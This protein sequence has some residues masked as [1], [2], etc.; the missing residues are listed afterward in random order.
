MGKFLKNKLLLYLIANRISFLVLLYFLVIN[1]PIQKILPFKNFFDFLMTFGKRWD[2][3]SYAFIAD[4]WYVTAGAE[5]FFIVFP[6][7]YPILIKFLTLFGLG[8]VLSGIILSNFF[9]IAAMLLFYKLLLLD[10]KKDFAL[11]VIVIISIFPT[12]FF[13]S[14][15]Y[16]ESLFVFLFALSFYLSRKKKYCLS[17][18][19][20]GLAAI[21]RPFG[22]IILPAILF[23]M[24]I[25]KEL[26][27]KNILLI[28]LPFVIP[29]LAYL[30]INYTIYGNPTAYVDLLKENWQKS[31]A[32]PWQGIVSSWK[33]GVFTTDSLS[34]KYF[35]GYGEAAASTLVWIFIPVGIWRWGIK[36]SYTVYLILATILFTSTGFIL[37]APRYLLS[38][39]PFFILLAEVIKRS[40]LLIVLWFVL[41]LSLLFYISNEFAWGHWTF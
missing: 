6:P 31:F 14:V 37:S 39:P 33:R 1:S 15:A 30:Y 10:Y 11:L 13:F 32:F 17:G 36:S 34:Y 18:L 22:I 21:T 4:H 9:F 26:R 12:G 27:I 40:K 25:N 8:S 41:S 23:Q 24:V 2:G 38:I 35:T 3:N 16:P 20:G 19:A 29:F 28:V 7:L 5:R